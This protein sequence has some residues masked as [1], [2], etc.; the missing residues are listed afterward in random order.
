[1]ERG[2]YAEYRLVWGEGGGRLGGPWG[3]GGWGV[4]GG[5][6][7]GGPWGEGGWGVRGGRD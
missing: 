2:A 1:M 3:E 6:E 4:P 7:L 5:R